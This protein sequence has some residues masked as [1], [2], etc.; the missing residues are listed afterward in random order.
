MPEFIA[1]ADGS[2]A[3]KGRNLLLGTKTPYAWHGSDTRSVSD[4]SVP[5]KF[6]QV[7]SAAYSNAYILM[8]ERTCVPDASRNLHKM[9]EWLTLSLDVKVSGRTA[10]RV[11]ASYDLRQ[12]GSYPQKD[13]TMV[14]IS[15]HTEWTRTSVPVKVDLV[16]NE[17]QIMSP[18]IITCR[19]CNQGITVEWQNMK[20]E[21]GSEPTAY[22]P[23]PEDEEVTT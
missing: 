21:F 17:A 14:D 1:L 15:D 13:Q 23:A 18:F 12:T 4:I 20:L 11:Y 7:G 5:G 19:D 10:G 6:V 2:L 3:V 22:S 8:H 9:D 16:K